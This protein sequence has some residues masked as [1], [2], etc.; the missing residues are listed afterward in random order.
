MYPVLLGVLLGTG[1]GT[2]VGC[3]GPTTSLDT[4]PTTGTTGDAATTTGT[5]EDDGTTGEP[6]VLCSEECTPHLR[7]SWSYEGPE[8][9]R[10]VVEMLRD[11]DGSLTL[12]TQQLH[13]TVGVTRL[14]ATGELEWAVNPGMSCHDCQLTDIALHPSGDVLLSATEPASMG[15]PPLSLVARFD[16]ATR[17][18]VWVRSLTMSPTLSGRPRTGELVVLDDD[19]IVQVRVDGH[20][21]IESIEVIDLD[22]EGTMRWERTVLSQPQS[23]DDWPPLAVRGVGGDLVLGHAWWDS[24]AERMQAASSRLLPPL[25]SSLSRLPLTLT[26]DDLVVDAAGRRI[27]LARSDGT[28]TITLRVTSRRGSDPER[29][30][31][32]LPLLSTANARAALAVGPDDDVYVAA[33]TTPRLAP[34]EPSVVVSLDVARWTADGQLRWSATRPLDMMATSDPIELVVDEDD[35]VIVGTVIEGQLHVARFEQA[36]ACE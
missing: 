2:G 22:A 23:G 19:R 17:E 7:P 29:W 26:L 20:D 11:S 32:S 8:G 1:L 14:T 27:E 28:E 36:C 3:R 33:R 35:G 25:Y 24:E 10:T 4:T 30:S 18:L 34:D 6:V 9:H 13:G 15:A 21:D 16:V 5:G 31:S 12:G